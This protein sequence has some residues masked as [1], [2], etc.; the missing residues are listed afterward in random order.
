MTDNKK[1][2]KP[3]TSKKDAKKIRSLLAFINQDLKGEK[4]K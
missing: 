4:R 3:K 1:A 2:Y